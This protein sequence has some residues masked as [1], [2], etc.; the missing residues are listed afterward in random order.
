M[1]ESRLAPNI[2]SADAEK[3]FLSKEDYHLSSYLSI[4]YFYL[5]SPI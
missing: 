4:I 5:S 3:Y 2:S 1:S